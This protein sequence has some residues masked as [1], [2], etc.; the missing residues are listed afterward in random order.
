MRAR[1]IWLVA[2]WLAACDRSKTF[3]LPDEPE[4]EIAFAILYDGDD[5]REIGEVTT[6]E[7][8]YAGQYALRSKARGLS[9]RLFFAK[10]EDVVAQADAACAT[11]SDRATVLA[12]RGLLSVCA[13]EPSKCLAIVE[14]DDC[15]DRIPI[16][17]VLPLIGFQGDGELS[18]MEGESSADLLDGA[19]MC[20]PPSVPAC[21]ARAPGFVV[22]ESGR[23]ACIARS[24][25]VGC[26]LEIDLSACGLGVS[27]GTLSGDGAF[28]QSSGACRIEPL[29]GTTI[30]GAEGYDAVCGA[31]RFVLS[32]MGE[33][34]G[35]GGCRH[36]GSSAF[37][38]YF[39]FPGAI[40]AFLP[41]EPP[42]WPRRIAMS[43]TGADI[44]AAEG[45]YV[46]NESCDRC[47]DYCDI[48]FE[49]PECQRNDWPACVGLDARED[50]LRRCS[51]WCTRPNPSCLDTAGL[52]V[53]THAPEQPELELLRLDLDAIGTAPGRSTHAMI[54]LLPDLLAVATD[55]YVA[56]VRAGAPDELDVTGQRLMPF[57]VAGL[58]EHPA[59]GELFAFGTA[60][61]TA[62]GHVAHLRVT[63]EPPSLEAI[64]SDVT[65]PESSGF[66]RAVLGGDR[67]L[68]LGNTS[69]PANAARP[70]AIDLFP[71]DG[72]P[73]PP[74]ID[75]GARLTALADLPGDLILAATAEQVFAIVLGP[76]GAEATTMIS[77]IPGLR[78][79][80]LAIDAPRCDASVCRVYA[81]LE[82]A[83]SRAWVGILEVRPAE[84]SS[85]RMLPALIET[86]EEE[87]SILV[88]D[89]DTLYAV[90][91]HRNVITPIERLR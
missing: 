27:A 22:T 50:C 23:V 12:C 32:W 10:L 44:C 83:G 62:R 82:R 30:A 86:Y 69:P 1:L 25:Q 85:S 74:P 13:T 52:V 63:G 66:D 29:T 43:G 36:E 8:V 73:A 64:L 58:V 6:T 5:L 77:G 26:A 56:L 88:A 78:I 42:G 21:P 51:E 89:G 45:C 9:V 17:G 2:P 76:N 53:T 40:N 38:S 28:V 65:V 57:E 20:G 31:T 75:L 34:F 14:G 72:S 90:A 80:A 24:T 47:F 39:Q 19:A 81:G 48:Q 91:R 68:I 18:A 16:P 79:S 71:A 46:R 4:H 3:G 49:F 61:A 59:G 33:A 54:D 35:D 11:L 60:G 70:N 41:I 55:E 15:G 37:D 87:L 84:L 7:A 67:F